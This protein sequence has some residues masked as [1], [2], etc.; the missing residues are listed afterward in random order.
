[1]RLRSCLLPALAALALTARAHA[2]EA[3]EIKP[4]VRLFDEARELMERGE[5]APA[6]PKLE[7]SQELD[8]Q[9]GTQLHL[10]H[11]YE[12]LGQLPAAYRTFLAAAEL[13]ALRNQQGADEPREQVA[14]E[15]ASSLEAR[16]SL[17]ELRPPDS[18][19]ELAITLDDTPVERERWHKLFPIEPGEHSLRATARDRTPW[20]QRFSISAPAKRRI[21]IPVLQPITPHETLATAPAA[22][23]AA[24]VHARR[25]PASLQRVVGY[26]SLGAGAV[27]LGLGTL[28]G[29][30]QTSRVTELSGDC[31]LDRG[32]CMIERGDTLARE[33]IESLHDQASSFGTAANIAWIAGGVAAATGVVLIL[34]TPREDKP[35]LTLGIAPAGLT[36]TA[37]TAG[38]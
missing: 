15:R 1:M 23:L 29:L 7:Q 14:R 12:K 37:H 2:E 20:E 35:A 6:C 18:P 9:L 25:S 24:P 27:G 5:Y 36:L 26:V 19:P 22:A 10:G 3:A 21:T 17:L 11:C 32:V 8:P 16:L 4:A 30:L 38:L 31:D 33:R 28:F 13:A 34:T